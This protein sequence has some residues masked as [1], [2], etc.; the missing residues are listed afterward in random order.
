MALDLDI[1]GEVTVLTEAELLDP[2]QHTVRAT[3]TLRESH[4]GVARLIAQGMRDLDVSRMTGYSPGR[5]ATLRRDPAFT[6]LVSFYKGEVDDAH[7]D[8][9]DYAQ[10]VARDALQSLHEDI[11]DNPYIR[12]EIKA[13]IFKTVADRAGFA[14]VQRSISRSVNVSIAERMD[15]VTRKRGPSST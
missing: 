5:L 12:P 14:P 11:L 1:A 3:A 7:M 2:P 15:A 10:V 9:V 8:L 4:H 13:D 6:E